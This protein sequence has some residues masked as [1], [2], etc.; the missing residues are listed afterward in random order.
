MRKEQ[1]I[2]S[3]IAMI[4][5]SEFS[6]LVA[7]EAGSLGIKIDLVTITT[8]LIMLSSILMALLIKHNQKIYYFLDGICPDRLKNN[9]S[10]L[11]NYIRSFLQRMSTENLHTKDFKK[12]LLSTLKFSFLLLF[13]VI[14]A[15][16]V[17]KL[18]FDLNQPVYAYL[19]IVFAI[20]LGA[21]FIYNI[22]TSARLVHDEGTKIMSYMHGDM[23]I[24]RADLILR[25]ITIGFVIIIFGLLSP[26]IL[27]ALGLPSIFCLVSIIIIIA[28][29]VV[30]TSVIKTIRN[31]LADSSF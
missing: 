11:G 19:L 14:T 25:H 6:L 18:L 29:I 26:L 2:F 23:N 5:V 7:K 13:L 22:A 17:S 3:G 20:L 24:E 1:P 27:F 31:S 15:H 16:K 12:W 21:F 8:C 4:A 10:Y 30:I 9:F 28:G